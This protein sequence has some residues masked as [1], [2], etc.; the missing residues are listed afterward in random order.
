MRIA[1]YCESQFGQQLLHKIDFQSHEIVAMTP[2]GLNQ[3][4]QWKLTGML[5]SELPFGPGSNWFL[6]NVGHNTGK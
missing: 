5:K 4:Q 2:N 6:E 1:Y 3:L